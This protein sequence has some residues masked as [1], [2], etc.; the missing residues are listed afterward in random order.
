MRNLLKTDL[1]RFVRSKQFIILCI[2]S[3][4]IAVGVPVLLYLLQELIK[5]SSGVSGDQST[6]SIFNAKDFTFAGY[7]FMY[8]LRYEG[9][10]I[11]MINVSFILTLILFTVLLANEF[12]YGIVRNKLIVGHSRVEIYLSLILTLFI[13]MFGLAFISSILSLGMA[14]ILFFYDST[15]RIF[16]DDFGSIM[17]GLLM[18]G[19][20]YT[21]VASVICFFAVGLGK[22]PLAI[23]LSLVLAFLGYLGYIICDSIIL[24][25][26]AEGSES[27]FIDILTFLNCVNIYKEMSELNS[28]SYEPYQIIAYIFN[29]LGW[30]ALVSFLGIKI[31][32]KRDIK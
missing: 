24:V 21:F 16:I 10:A 23:V 15:G 32:E 7:G 17:L 1:L 5:I 13:F 28:L 9:T 11:S 4:V 27:N 25:L 3:A 2:L 19:C 30:T 6:V 14:G 31:F 29:P 8:T 22:T 20:A 12:S 26:R 18:G